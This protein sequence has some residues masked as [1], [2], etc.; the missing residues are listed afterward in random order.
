MK[1]LQGPLPAEWARPESSPDP[2]GI[3]AY[4]DYNEGHLQNATDSVKDAIFGE[5]PF[6]RQLNDKSRN[7][8]KK[9]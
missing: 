5:Y 7:P 1:D 8:A 2:D 4:P 9:R 6:D 3:S